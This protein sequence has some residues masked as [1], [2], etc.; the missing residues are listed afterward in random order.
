M[1]AETQV[2]YH[3]KVRRQYLYNSELGPYWTYGL[4]V[5]WNA[6]RGLEKAELRDISL[7]PEP[8][9]QMADQFTRENLP[10]SRL[11]AAVLELL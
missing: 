1:P 10:A 7:Y 4:I 5:F 3:Y 9:Q 11:K 6:G 8:V 2:R